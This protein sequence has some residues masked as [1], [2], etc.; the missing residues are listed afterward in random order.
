[1]SAP[2]VSVIVPQFGEF[3]RTERLLRQLR[4]AHA[5]NCELIVVDDG[6]PGDDPFPWRA[7]LDARC[8]RQMHRGVT[9]AWNLGARCAQG[10]R[11]VFLNNDV[12]AVSSFLERLIE[13]LAAAGVSMTGVEFRR[14]TAV[15]EDLLRPGRERLLAG[16]CFALRRADF[17]A[18]GGFD[19]RFVLYFSDTDL[20]WRIVDAWGT[21]ALAVVRGLPLRHQG[22]ATT[23]QCADRRA[24]W[25]RDREE[26]I[27]KWRRERGKTEN[28]T[29]KTEH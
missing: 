8:V 10:E 15:P 9:A 27:R 29:L 4:A 24:L 28:L 3:A 23:R 17:A 12:E 5:G 6:S 21:A 19:E 1:M 13:P 2:A 14:E 11:L 7:R 16:W 20:Q 25:R 18:L 26:F 22:H